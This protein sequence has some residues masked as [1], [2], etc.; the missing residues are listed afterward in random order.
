MRYFKPLRSLGAIPGLVFVEVLI[1]SLFAP[2][3]MT[4]NNLFNVLYNASA[5]AIIAAGMTLV[6]LLAG[7]D[8]SAGPM[9]GVIGWCVAD[10][11]TNGFPAPVTVLLAILLGGAFGLINGVLVVRGRVAPII[12]TL[13]TAA[14]FK[15]L[16]FVLWDSND[17]F[18]GPV[19]SILG[20]TRWWFVPRASLLVAV[21]YFALGFVLKRTPWGRGIYAIGNDAEGARLLGVPVRSVTLSTY[22]TV[23][24]LA[25]FTALA[26]VSRVGVIQSNSGEELTLAAI[27]AVVIGGT[28]IL[29][30][31][32]GV[33]R[34]LL[35]VLF[36]AVLSNGLVLIGVP[37]IWSGVFVGGAVAAAAVIDVLG[38][39]RTGPSSVMEVS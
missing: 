17:I 14:I 33:G 24:C 26:Y 31:R 8:I 13:G 19:L 27:A 12:A 10:M 4:S 16:L 35:G 23:G 39:K 37:S 36:V 2:R 9:V 30:G 20:P 22:G 25:G 29:G 15:S 1:F 5:L 18:T 11:A 21:I 32:G 6:I 3:F 28:S 7:I 38:R 34:T